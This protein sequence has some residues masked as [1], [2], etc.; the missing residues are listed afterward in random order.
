MTGIFVLIQVS[1]SLGRGH[2]NVGNTEEDQIPPVF[3]GEIDLGWPASYD[4]GHCHAAWLVQEPLTMD[5]SN[6]V[7]SLNDV[8]G[9]ENAYMS[10]KFLDDQHLSSVSNSC[11]L[12]MWC[13]SAADTEYPVWRLSF[14]LS[15][16]FLKACTQCPMVQYGQPLFKIADFDLMHFAVYKCY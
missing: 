1:L 8:Q 6:K 12:E 16:P 2:N 10:G 7:L 14:T 3:C 9:S 4:I 15:P 5:T 11:R 13:W